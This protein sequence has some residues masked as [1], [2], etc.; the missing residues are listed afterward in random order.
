MQPDPA[1]VLRQPH[2]GSV[3]V[4]VSG[5]QHLAQVGVFPLDGE[6]GVDVGREG[7]EQ[8]QEVLS[9]RRERDGE[10]DELL[11]VLV[12]EEFLHDGVLKLQ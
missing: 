9:R 2:H 8:V 6:L 7:E 12:L 3:S 5:V 1:V 11:G 10:V 4:R